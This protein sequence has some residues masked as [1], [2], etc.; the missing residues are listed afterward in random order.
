MSGGRDEA[1]ADCLGL[2]AEMADSDSRSGRRGRRGR[3]K[4]IEL[5]REETPD[6]FRDGAPARELHEAFALL[7]GYG[8]I[9]LLA[10]TAGGGGSLPDHSSL[11]TYVQQLLSG[12]ARA[13]PCGTGRYFR[14]PSALLETHLG[15]ELSPAL[16]RERGRQASALRIEARAKVGGLA[17]LL[18]GGME[19]ACWEEFKKE[20]HHLDGAGVR[21]LGRSTELVVRIEIPQ[22]EATDAV[23]LELRQFCEKRRLR[24]ESAE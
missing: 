7:L 20:Y 6:Y 19:R 12:E 21:K 18:G 16:L 3:L 17:K 2:R 13:R 14:T 23:L 8:A 11:R 10:Q 9:E 24:M 22:H 4:F 15:V 5:C 1:R